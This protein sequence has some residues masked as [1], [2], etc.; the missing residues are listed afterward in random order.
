MKIKLDKAVAF[1]LSIGFE[2]ANE[3]DEA[4]VLGRIKQAPS[5]V[6]AEDVNDEFKS[7]YDALCE[8]GSDGIFLAGGPGKGEVDLSTLDK[9]GLQI[10][11]EEQGLGLKI[12]SRDALEKVRSQVAN[13]LKKKDGKPVVKEAKS[14]H[15][16]T[17]DAAKDV[18]KKDGPLPTSKRVVKLKAVRDQ[19]GCEENTISAKV[20]AVVKD[21]WQTEEEINE[22]CKLSLDKTRGRLYYAAERGI[23]EYRRL[24]QYR[25]TQPKAKK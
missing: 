3:W 12:N 5:K 11:N 1:L 20:N 4:K 9:K 13:A 19:W 10:I 25:W 22:K 8:A 16:K 18:P 21:D 7:F 15:A 24:T 6:K 23:M 14:A 17:E 2:K